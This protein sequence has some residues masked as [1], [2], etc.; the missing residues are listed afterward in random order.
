MSEGRTTRRQALRD[1][2][3]KF[4]ARAV[5]QG[6]VDELEAVQIANQQRKRARVT[7]RMR[8][9]LLQAIVQQDAI[10]QA[11][12]CI[13]GGQMPQLL[14]RGFQSA[15]ARRDQ[16]FEAQHMASQQ[17]VIFPF[18]AERGGALHNLD[19]FGGFAQYQ[20]LV[21]VAQPLHHLG[22]VVVG[23]GRTNDHLHLGIR[24]PQAFDGFQAIPPRR[25]AHV[26][27]RHRVRPTL[28][29]RL[30]HHLDA[31]FPL[32]R[33]VDVEVRP[34][35]HSRIAAE[36]IRFQHIERGLRG[37]LGLGAQDLAEIRMNGRIVVDDQDAP[38]AE[39]ADA[40]HGRLRPRYREARA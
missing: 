39:R 11:R 13:V 5:S 15:R 33:G 35:R 2:L 27:E 26:D 18:A 31:F 23:V 38:V 6:I 1:F 40:R 28:A 7:V 30:V 36:Q 37:M 3:Q 14:I 8:D 32:M 16:V 10:R 34:R 17:P 20:Q 22:P 25:H 12:Q 4:I 29:E 21:G 9:G 19:R 24:R